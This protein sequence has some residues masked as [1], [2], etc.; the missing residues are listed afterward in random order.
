MGGTSAELFKD[1]TLQFPPLNENLARKMIESLKIYPLLKGWRGDTPKNID[2][3]VEVMMRLSQ[4]VS[5]YPEIKELDINPLIVTADDAIALDARIVVDEKI[6]ANPIPE[7]SHLIIAPCPEGLE[8]TAKLNNGTSVTLRPIKAEDEPKWIEMLK[9]SSSK[10]ENFESHL[11]ASPYCAIDYNREIA[12]V[13]EKDGKF[14]GVTR[15]GINANAEKGKSSIC[16]ANSVKDTDIKEI[17]SKY[18][19]EIA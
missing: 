15:K 1:K 13:A 12:V 17:L 18:L 7:F 10:V 8:K 2:K 6:M 5:D 19:K 14:L 9:G 11:I 4:M 16:I 3:L